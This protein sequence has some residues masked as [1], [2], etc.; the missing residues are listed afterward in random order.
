MF[1]TLFEFKLFPL[2]GYL[3]FDGSDNPCKIFLFF[4]AI[5]E[6]KLKLVNG[7]LLVD[8]LKNADNKFRKGSS[9]YFF[10]VDFEKMLAIYLSFSCKGF[11]QAFGLL[12]FDG[13]GEW[14]D[15]FRHKSPNN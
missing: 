4:Y 14:E 13:R 2:K 5:K 1:L 12:F 15:P 10:R 11:S 7:P 3:P 9:C 6:L 8:L